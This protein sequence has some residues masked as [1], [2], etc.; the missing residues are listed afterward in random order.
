MPGYT[1]PS[2][3]AWS[4]KPALFRSMPP[5]VAAGRG[6]YKHERRLKLVLDVVD[7]AT[8][9]NR[10]FARGMRTE[11]L[12]PDI[13]IRDLPDRLLNRLVGI[14]N[15]EFSALDSRLVQLKDQ[16]T[17]DFRAGCAALFDLKSLGPREASGE[18][19]FGYRR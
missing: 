15:A 9:A 6:L 7:V 2:T 11:P 17:T 12:Q 8:T 14:N 19:W 5:S 4:R 18:P 16:L 1:T 13:M 3:N 10:G